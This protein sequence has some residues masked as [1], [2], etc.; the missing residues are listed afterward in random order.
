MK[1]ARFAPQTVRFTLTCQYRKDRPVKPEYKE[2]DEN[3]YGE[4][5][6]VLH[7]VVI[8]GQMWITRIHTWV[9][10]KIKILDEMARVDAR[11]PPLA[12]V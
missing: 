8:L 9:I 1:K 10:R 7:G 5:A 6:K 4:F 12:A 3:Q 2:A 11:A